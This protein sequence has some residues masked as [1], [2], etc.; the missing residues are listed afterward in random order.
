MP[1]LIDPGSMQDLLNTTWVDAPKVM[2]LEMDQEEPD[3]EVKG[4]T[5]Y[6]ADIEATEVN[7][8][9]LEVLSKKKTFARYRY[10]R[11]YKRLFKGLEISNLFEGAPK[12]QSD[13]EKLVSEL[14]LALT[15][16]ESAE[17]KL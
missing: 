11:S 4:I 5:N 1:D 13:L 7:K 6:S 15:S 16:M 14:E 3:T 9:N 8:A 2:A 10:M 17:Q 12:Q